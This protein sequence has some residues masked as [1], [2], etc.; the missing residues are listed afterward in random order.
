MATDFQGFPKIARFSREI[1]ITEKLDGTNAQI[2]I[3][4]DPLLDSFVLRVGSRSRWLTLDDD[5]FGFAAWT[6]EHRDELIRGLGPGRHFGEWWGKGIQR[7]YGLKE[8]RFS[9]FNASRW[10]EETMPVCCHVVPM[11]Y[12]GPPTDLAIM[13]ALSVLEAGGSRAAPGFMR[14]EGVIIYHTAANVLFKKTLEDDN[15]KSAP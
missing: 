14:P 9:L 11:I 12:R 5:N 8:R 2:Y 15:A 1:I 10:T 7:G 3:E 4:P 13:S 6:F